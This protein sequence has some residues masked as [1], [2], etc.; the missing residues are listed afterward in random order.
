MMASNILSR[1]LPSASDEHSNY[2]HRHRRNP[3]DPSDI[4]DGLSMDID[5]ENLG[6]RFQ[7]QDLD[8]LLADATSSHITTESTA[9]LN[10]ERR[11]S[12]PHAGSRAN[13]GRGPSATRRGAHSDDDDDVPE[14]LLL[15]GADEPPR[16]SIPANRRPDP[17]LPPPVPGLASR[18]ART[19]W[20]TAQAQQR[21]H[22]DDRHLPRAA[23][24]P[25][26]AGA[27][28][29]S[30]D[31]KERAMWMWVN[32]QDLD[33]FLRKVYHYYLGHGIWS[34]LLSRVLALLQSAFI[35]GFLTFL[36]FCIN[37][38]NLS[39]SKTMEEV[40]V[41]KCTQ[42][43]HGFWKL[44][45][46]IFI[47]T[48]FVQLAG[49][50][51]EIP[52]LWNMY[53]FYHYLL[54][55]PD[56]NIQS[57]SWQ[58]IVSRLMALR[59]SNY[60]TAQN[61]SPRARR[62][63][64]DKSRQR[65]DAH[66][67]ANRVMR[68]DNY[69]IAIFNKDVMDLGVQIPFLG[70][71]QFFSRTTE[72]HVGLSVID[73][74]FGQN[75]E[76]DPKFL[77]ESNRREL[78][79][80]LNARFRTTAMISVVCAPVAVLF[81]IASL[82]FKY[83]TEYHKDPSQLGTRMFTPLAQWKFREFNE[84]PHQFERREKMAYP[85]ADRY[86]AM[87]PKDKTE[88]LAGFV[89]FVAGAFAAVLGMITLYDSELFLGF[90]ITPGRNVIFYLGIF[91]VIY[92]I[93]RSSSRKDE[94]VV[95]AGYAIKQVIEYTRYEPASWKGR[96]NTDEVRNEFSSLYQLKVVIFIEELLSILITPYILAFKL[97][98]STERIVDFFREFTV[99]VDGLGSVCSFAVFDFKRGGENNHANDREDSGLREDY[100]TTKDNKM[101]ASYY[102]FLDN[103]APAGR[104]H[105]ARRL[106][107]RRNFHPPPV[108]PSA[109]A[110]AS[111]QAPPPEMAARSTSR[112]TTGRQSTQRRTSR[113]IPAP[114]RASPMNSILL[115]PHHQPRNS[116]LQKAQAKYRNPLTGL[117]DPDELDEADLPTRNSSR[118]MEE[119]SSFGDSWKTT[120]LAQADDEA[121]A[122]AQEE[123]RKGGQGGVLGILAQFG[124]AHTQGRGAGVG[125]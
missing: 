28:Q 49:L 97:T 90:E 19:Q 38:Q 58:L 71:R 80:K 91:G 64:Q 25:L 104:G 84:L 27:G 67:I 59:D 8:H 116:P 60:S 73:F 113:N 31:P 45:I 86:L 119:D 69:L 88:Q 16:Q 10:K 78:V 23:R 18:Q 52:A 7:E 51:R 109:L 41:P 77:K 33:D 22:N 32:V 79:D 105:N 40:L 74:A 100:Y 117:E 68:R 42:Q 57:A 12:G 17:Y 115:D 92:G 63:L 102:G 122:E 14:S 87:F 95:D 37:F 5:E 30:N 99:H 112:G 26:P 29:L 62:I 15:E 3:S 123:A 121:E 72:W 83:F 43:I 120:K 66:D 9:F 34:I 47:V 124:G 65:M 35:T 76:I 82:L 21:L 56:R 118:I 108:F 46:Y 125:I 55:V 11:T 20:E 96:L 94:L 48:W 36:V 75:N 107:N 85:F 54:D 81:F 2:D 6:E 39:S 98:N 70:T 111:T 44:F 103:Y 89:A 53:N 61:I 101:L 4:E 13:P 106:Q 114:G 93:A 1:L 24:G 50:L 110:G